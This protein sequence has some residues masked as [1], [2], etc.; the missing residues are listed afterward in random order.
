MELA[1]YILNRRICFH[2][3]NN[4]PDLSESDIPSPN[5]IPCNNYA[6]EEAL[7]GGSNDDEQYVQETVAPRQETAEDECRTCENDREDRISRLK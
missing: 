2:D 6:L 1:D 4:I 3:Y 7:V 5:L